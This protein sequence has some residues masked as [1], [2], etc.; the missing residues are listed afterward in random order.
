MRL[1]RRGRSSADAPGSEPDAEFAFL[2]LAQAAR[3]RSLAHQAFAEAGV[4]VVVR[5]GHLEAAD[6][7]VFGLGNLAATCLQLLQDGREK[8]WPEVVRRHAQVV[9]ASPAMDAVLTELPREEVLRR[10]YL[11][12]VGTATLPAEAWAWYRY[13]RPV[14]GDL[15]ELLAFDEPETVRMLRD[16]DVAALGLEDLRFAGLENLLRDRYD[17]HEVIRGPSGQSFHLVLGDSVYTASK[18]LVLPDLLARTVGEREPE[19]G[20]LV[21]VPHRHQIAFA[22]VEPATLLSTVR[23]LAGFTAGR[24]ED[25]VGPLSPYL[26]WWKDGRVVQVSFLDDAGTLSIDATGEF[27]DL[28][29]RLGLTG[30]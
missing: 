14:A 5:P 23:T 16:E 4:E 18:L 19:F 3:L 27:G 11:R 24:Y 9:L 15:V 6:G 1:W 12:L 25:G 30:E 2:T 7:R 29:R 13:A 20:V 28:L 22:L 21:A 10:T 8:A 26:Y 17:S